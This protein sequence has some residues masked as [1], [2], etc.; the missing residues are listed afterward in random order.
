M[1]PDGSMLGEGVAIGALGVTRMEPIPFTEQQI[2]LLE[3]VADHAVIASENA[4]LFEALQAAN[5]QL[6]E[7]SHQRISGGC[8]SVGSSFAYSETSR[9]ASAAYI[10][11]ARPSCIQVVAPCSESSGIV[12]DIRKPMIVLHP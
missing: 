1:S 11:S 6:A 7:A 10:Q 3:T 4:R 9:V 8:H 2:A 5:L 12:S